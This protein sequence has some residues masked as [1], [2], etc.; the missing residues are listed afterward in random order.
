MVRSEA[1]NGILAVQFF[2]KHLQGTL[3]VCHS[4]VFIYHQTLYL[5]EQRG[6]GR[7]HLVCTVHTTRSQ[8]A[9][10]RLL[11]F[12]NADLD[13]GGLCSQNNVVVDVEGVLCVA[14][15]MVL[16]DIE[17]FKVIVVQ[18][19]LGTLCNLKAHADDDFFELVEHHRQRMSFADD[20][21]FARQGNVQRFGSQTQVEH[22][23]FQLRFGL[24]QFFL[25]VASDLVCQLT[26]DRSFLRRQLAHLL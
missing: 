19:D 1:N 26:D 20:I 5:M 14:R 3:Q 9:D 18:L 8:D 13:W 6:V 25:D 24:L 10:W 7:I 11:V 22:L 17:C 15:R 21:L 16:W 2:N 12:H 4:D 23:I